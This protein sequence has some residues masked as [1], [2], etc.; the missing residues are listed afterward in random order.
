[1]NRSEAN[2]QATTSRAHKTHEADDSQFK[3]FLCCLKVQ[4]W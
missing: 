2:R 4:C 3:C 1:M